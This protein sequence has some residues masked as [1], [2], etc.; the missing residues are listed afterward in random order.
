MYV[1]MYIYMTSLEGNVDGGMFQSRPRSARISVFKDV[2]DDSRGQPA[3]IVS[4]GPLFSRC[5]ERG[6][7]K[8]ESCKA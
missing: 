7:L 4:A 1:C 3:F 8:A 2:S 5:R 6:E